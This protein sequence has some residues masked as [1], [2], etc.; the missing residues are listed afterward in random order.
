MIRSSKHSLKFTN[1]EKLDEVKNFI[2]YYRVMV[3]KFCNTLWNEYISET[4]SML[5]SKV[6]NQIV[7]NVNFDSRIRQCAAKQACS[8][9]KAVTS[10]QNKRLF[11]LK[12]LQKEG[13]C[14]KYLQRT[15]DLYKLTKPKLGKINVELDPRFIDIETG[16]SF[17]L[18]VQIDEIG[19]KRKI[20]IPVKHTFTSNKWNAEGKLKNSIRLNEN[21]I[22]LYYEVD[23]K[24]NTG[25]EIVGADQGK[26]TCL[27]FSDGQVTKTNKHNYDLNKI[28]D[29]L[30]KRK[31]GSKGF[32]RSQSHRKNY[33]NWSLN[34]LNFSHIKQINFEKIKYLRKG[35][36]CN[37]NMS[38][39]TYTLIKN[40]LILLSEDKG[41]VFVETENKFMSQRCSQC[42]WT[43]KSNRKGK[44]FK[45]T[46]ADCNYIADSDLNAA[47]NHAVELFELPQM[48]WQQR[49]NRS[50]GF[51][52]FKDCYVVG[53]EHIV[54]HVKKE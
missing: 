50:A 39:W 40:K 48:I 24:Y 20:R 14:T 51:F 22:T 18:F 21:F 25:T 41:F 16:N 1:Q 47:S 37:R 17:D 38:H 44:T 46:N 36:G 9:I 19:N 53:D 34:Q 43:H 5:G 54:R 32:R 27:S 42:G 13:K 49:I 4:P 7:T 26:I 11:K 23:K 8:I 10:K 2:K 30:S 29:V 3:I 31:K 33:V 12:E 35:K 45:C 15:I 28:I 52:W 6:C